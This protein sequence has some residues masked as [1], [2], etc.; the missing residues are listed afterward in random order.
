MEAVGFRTVRA[1][2]HTVNGVRISTKINGNI[3]SC[4][5]ND[6]VAV[7][8]AK[9]GYSFIFAGNKSCCDCFDKIGIFLTI[10]I[11]NR[12]VFDIFRSYRRS[13]I[14]VIFD[15][16]VFNVTDILDITFIDNNR[17]VTFFRF[18]RIVDIAA[19]TDNRE[20][21]HIM[22]LSV[23]RVSG[24]TEHGIFC[25]FCVISANNRTRNRL[26]VA[27]D[28]SIIIAAFNFLRGI[29]RNCCNTGS[30]YTSVSIICRYIS[31]Y[32]TIS[33]RAAILAVAYDTAYPGIAVDITDKRTILQSKSTRTGNAADLRSIALDIALERAVG[34]VH[35]TVTYKTTGICSIRNEICVLYMNVFHF[36]GKSFTDNNCRTVVRTHIT[37][38]CFCAVNGKIMYISFTTCSFSEKACLTAGTA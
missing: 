32:I 10:H 30:A 22:N 11:S 9:K 14:R 3:C 20:R 31:F 29:K 33:I 16:G 28:S 2:E 35:I 23:P 8:I 6:T 34:N 27:C 1:D 7:C 13:S 21:I 36:T 18:N 24:Y 25:Y 4:R 12:V 19:F 15:N 17:V 26:V 37:K 5:N 38:T